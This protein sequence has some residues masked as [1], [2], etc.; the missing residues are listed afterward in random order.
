MCLKY[1]NWTG[2]R[3]AWVAQKDG[4]Q[5]L[6]G[7]T[8]SRSE[9]KSS[10]SNG[11][12]LSSFHFNFK[13]GSHLTL[14]LLSLNKVE[15]EAMGGGNGN[16]PETYN[17]HFN[18]WFW[19]ISKSQFYFFPPKTFFFLQCWGWTHALKHASQVLYWGLPRQPQGV[20][21]SGYLRGL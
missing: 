10:K 11:Q 9:R 19:L 21:I 6:A 3:E 13:F 14:L 20:L 17:F 1:L 8:C 2:N 15:K 18:E 12:L 5:D 16:K 7:S 4:S